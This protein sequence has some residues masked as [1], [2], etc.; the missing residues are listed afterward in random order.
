M[1]LAIRTLAAFYDS[2]KGAVVRR[3]IAQRL[4][5]CWPDLARRRVLGVGYAVPYLGRLAGEAE[6]TIAAVPVGGCTGLPEAASGLTVLVEGQ[7]LP[8]ADASF[9]CLLLVHGLELVEARRSVM[10]EIW[11]VLASDGRL[12]IVAPNRTSL[13]AQVENTP[14]G[15]GQPYSRGQLRQL[16]EDS[17]FQVERWDSALFMP[18]F[19]RRS[20]RTGAAWDRVGRRIWPRFAG[21]H[22][23]EATK[24][25]YVPALP[26][27]AKARRLV[28]SVAAH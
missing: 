26:A 4:R 28:P 18:P 10:R 12:L 5:A 13:W 25:L 3:L 8:F 14:F 22:L 23:V 2:P 20:L 9:D 27:A 7:S 17:L 1:S 15:H 24:S 6:R 16:L 19:G 21:L 11:R